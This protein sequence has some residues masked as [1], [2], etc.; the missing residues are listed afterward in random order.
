MRIMATWVNKKDLPPP[1]P[2]TH[3]VFL[4]VMSQNYELQV[5]LENDLAN[6]AA[7]RGVKTVKSIDAFGAIV[8][9]D[10]LPKKEVLLK[11]IS[12]LGCDLIFSVALVDQKSE[13]HYT[14]GSVSGGYYPYGGF[15][16]FYGGYY[17]YAPTYYSPGYYS[18]DNTYFVESNLYD[19]KTEKLLVSMQSKVVNPPEVDKGSKKYTD[20]LIKEL[21]AQGFMKEPAKP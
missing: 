3:T 7:A 10:K 9:Q 19:L 2:G 13:T 1:A 8:S 17:A 11:A 21:L 16:G 20:M 12:D 6:A 14:P 15:G 18:T 4:F 5:E